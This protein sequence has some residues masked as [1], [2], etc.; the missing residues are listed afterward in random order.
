[1]ARSTLP[2]LHRLPACFAAC[3]LLLPLISR[4]A[5]GEVDGRWSS[6]HITGEITTAAYHPENGLWVGGNIGLLFD[7]TQFSQSSQKHLMRLHPSGFNVNMSLQMSNPVSAIQMLPDRQLLFASATATKLEKSSVTSNFSFDTAFSSASPAFVNAIGITPDQDFLLGRSA[8]PWLMKISAAGVID[9]TYASGPAEPVLSLA[10]ISDGSCLAGGGASGGSG[11]LT[12]ISPTG[13]PDPAFAPAFDGPVLALIVQPDAKILAAGRFQSVNGTPCTGLIRLLPDGAVDTSFQASLTGPPGATGVRSLLPQVDGAILISGTFTAVDGTPRPGMA[14]LTAVGALDPGFASL[15]PT[16]YGNNTKLLTLMPDG[17][18]VADVPGAPGKRQIIML[19]NGPG[20]SSLTLTQ[21]D[22]VTWARSGALPELSQ[23]WFEKLETNASGAVLPAGTLLGHGIRTPGG[24][25]LSSPN[26]PVSGVIRALGIGPSA[27]GQSSGSLVFDTLSLGTTTSKMT[28]R[29]LDSSFGNSGLAFNQGLNGVWRGSTAI[30]PV[31]LRNDGLSSLTGLQ[32]TITGP[33]AGL[34]SIIGAPS[35]IS[36][37]EETSPFAVG[38]NSATNIINARATL[39]IT[40]DTPSTPALTI[41]LSGSAASSRSVTFDTAFSPAQQAYG[42]SASGL[43]LEG[44]TFNTSAPFPVGQDLVLVNNVSNAPISG[45][46][47]GWLQGTVRPLLINGINRPCKIDYLGGDGNDLVLRPFF[48]VNVDSGFAALFSAYQTG[49]VYGCIR[50]RNGCWLIAGDLSRIL[51]ALNPNQISNPGLVRLFPDGSL[52]ESFRPNLPTSTYISV[53]E[54]ESGKILV[55]TLDRTTLHRFHADGS[56]DT[57]FACSLND[58]ADSVTP[59]AGDRTLI[60]GRFV[61]VNGIARN[62]IAMLNADGALDASFEA[63]ANGQVLCS[64]PIP[65]G[66]FYIGGRFNQINGSARNGLAHLSPDGALLPVGQ[67][68]LLPGGVHTLAQQQSGHI[69]CGSSSPVSVVRFHESGNLGP[70]FTSTGLA[71]NGFPRCIIPQAN[72][73]I[74]VG[75]AAASP[76]LGS[77]YSFPL[78]AGRLNADGTVDSTFDTFIRGTSESSRVEALGLH[79]SNDGTVMIGGDF[80][81]AANMPFPGF[82]RAKLEAPTESLT[83]SSPARIEW[84]R[85]GSLPDTTDISFALHQPLTNGW[86]PLGRGTAIPGGWE[87]T[88]LTLPA[89]GAI[90]ATARNRGGR[91]N[92]SHGFADTILSFGA[93]SPDISLH[94]ADG[95]ALPHASAV[96]ALRSAATGTIKSSALSIENHGSGPLQLLAATLHGADAAAFSFPLFTTTPLP[97]GQTRLLPLRFSPT[98]ARAYTAQLTLA[99]NDPDTPAYTLT[100]SGTATPIQAWREET[101]N[102]IADAGS[103]ANTADPDQDGLTNLAEYALGSD[104]LLADAQLL[105][106][107]FPSTASL[108]LALTLPSFRA[109]IRY[110]AESSPDPGA[111]LWSNVP[112]IGTAFYLN[113]SIPRTQARQFLRLRFTLQ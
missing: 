14:R 68:I 97:A 74:L 29:R 48:S 37:V 94:R 38:F 5:P 28:L 57:T 32:F 49:Q 105:P 33:S 91:T 73:K 111:A 26:L 17:R 58:W 40:S 106:T 79:L 35:G 64:L 31:G 55:G 34:F 71:L 51:P 108:Q 2:F 6:L 63:Q 87:L 30:I 61:T 77:L 81:R 13:I 10:V 52:D 15:D 11:F 66:T 83:V 82:F 4:A 1:M 84:L 23:V 88:G 54:T 7:S 76:S 95:T 67:A 44:L 25:K 45:T 78:G 9:S 47:S 104:P 21:P 86:L 39:T 103:A 93:V 99:T 100:G 20:T 41:A 101:F 107:I 24:W 89:D 110:S 92:S 69:L 19:Q 80:E 18:V 8:A 46:L 3:G 112:N 60:T 43:T 85:G 72:G 113:F 102:S 75:M 27:C 56:T 50:Q 42:F 70:T 53:S 16:R 90:R 59:L 62:R 96:V 98:A 12:K 22:E 36:N 109:D 65:D